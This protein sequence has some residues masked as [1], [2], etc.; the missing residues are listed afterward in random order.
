MAVSLKPLDRQVMVITGASS[1]IG[2]VTAR[3][4]AKAGASLLL[5]ARSEEALAA[6][7]REIVAAGGAADYAV[8][9]VGDAAAVEAVAARAVA[10]FGR[11][12]T[13]V[14]DAGVAIYGKL[15]DTPADEHE[16]L[17]RTNYFGMVNG[18]RAAVPHLRA[19][20]GVLITVGSIASDLPSPLMGAY[21]ASKHAI[22][23][24][25]ETL[26]MELEA[27]GAPI[28]VTLIKPSGIDTPIAEHA[29]DRAGGAARIP[30]PPY[31]PALVANAILDAAVHPRREITIGGVGRAE[32]L[33][34]EHFPKTFGRIAPMMARLFVDR[35]KPQP[36]PDNLFAP[37]RDGNERS[38]EQA[39][40]RFSLYTFAAEH[41]KAMLGIGALVGGVLLLARRRSRHSG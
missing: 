21:A 8:A 11:I 32:V 14:N 33:F 23:A 9:D 30:P 20:G 25:V 35:S 16:R 34:G 12:D 13:W 37:A 28:S 40:R 41:R 2:L 31:D 26:R 22:K 1:G 19:G 7:C 27:E 3:A 36:A 10:R 15:M 39:G 5:V 4:A 29:A 38:G 24:Y 6:I 17:F 18:A